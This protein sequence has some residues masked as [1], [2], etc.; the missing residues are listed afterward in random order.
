MRNADLNLAPPLNR[1]AGPPG[2][3]AGPGR[4]GRAGP[5]WASGPGRP[6]RAWAGLGPGAT[7]LGLAGAAGLAGLGRPVQRA[8]LG[9]APAS[10]PA[11]RAPGRGHRARAFG[12]GRQAA[13]GRLR[14][15]ARA[16][17][18]ARLRPAIGQFGHK[19]III[20]TLSLA[21]TGTT[22]RQV[23]AGPGPGPQAPQ[24]YIRFAIVQPFHSS[25]P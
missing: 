13:L 7:G 5:G 21:V 10:R 1:W 12:P 20:N 18:L 8:G 2:R 19:A 16:R 23:G 15:G 3:W 9:L 11:R 4:R 22:G 17:R 25:P 24:Q 6:G 14:A